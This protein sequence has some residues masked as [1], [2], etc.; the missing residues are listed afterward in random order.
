[1]AAA[2]EQNRERGEREKRI[3]TRNLVAL[4]VLAGF[5]LLVYLAT[6]VKVSGGGG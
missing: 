1:M 3:R 4:V 2:M 5:T 6:F